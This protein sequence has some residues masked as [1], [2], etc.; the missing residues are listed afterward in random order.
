MTGFAPGQ[1]KTALKRAARPGQPPPTASCNGHKRS[2]DTEESRQQSCATQSAS[3]DGD[4]SGHSQQMTRQASEFDE[5]RPEDLKR[6][7]AH[8]QDAKS[9]MEELDCSMAAILQAKVLSVLADEK[10]A[11]P[12]CAAANSED[13][14]RLERVRNLLVVD[15]DNRMSLQIENFQCRHCN[16][17]VTVHPYALD[18]VP[19]A[20]TVFCR[21]WI[22]RSVVNFFRD[23]HKNNGLSANGKRPDARPPLGLF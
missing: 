15:F 3:G 16:E 13:C 22:R 6:Y 10:A 21:T 17:F 9:V 11:H 19:T 2:R 18:C 23:L 4:Q 8:F 7:F 5:A 20:P 12:C 1:P 14:L